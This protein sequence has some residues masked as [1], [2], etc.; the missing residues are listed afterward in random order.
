MKICG[1]DG[2]GEKHHGKGYCRRHYRQFVKNGKI[3][4][5]GDYHRLHK[6]KVIDCGDYLA[7]E[8]YSKSGEV[9]GTTLFD[10]EDYDKLKD[11]K[12][13][14]SRGYAYTT[15]PE[16]NRVT[17]MTHMILDVSKG[18]QVDHINGNKLDNRKKN[19]RLCTIEQNCF[20]TGL[21]YNSTSG[22]R[23]VSFE[24]KRGSPK[25]WGAYIGIRGKKI[26][27]G[28]FLTK[29]EAIDVRVA[30]EPEY[31]GEFSPTSSRGMPLC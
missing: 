25:K 29:Q 13:C 22:F 4:V 7:L 8:L 30:A 20:N 9:V 11:F 16:G 18:R 26:N 23:G 27:L 10:K 28:Y 15:I 6:N 31:Y 17:P 21:R 12:W 14:M 24:S 2:C 3:T 5:F 19:I 1:V